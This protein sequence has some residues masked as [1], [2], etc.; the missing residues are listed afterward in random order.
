VKNKPL[1][2]PPLWADEPTMAA[3]LCMGESTFREY[4]RRGLVP[5]G[6]LIGSLRRW[7]VDAVSATLDRLGKTDSDTADPYLQKLRG[8]KHG[9]KTTGRRHD[10]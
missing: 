5:E 6:V 10:A 7:K 4:A 2:Y 1:P 3:L 8:G 9:T